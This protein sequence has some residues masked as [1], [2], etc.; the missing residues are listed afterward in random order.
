MQ[1]RYSTGT[2]EPTDFPWEAA[3]PVSTF[4]D[5]FTFKDAAC[6][7]KAIPVEELEQHDL[8]T[9]YGS[10][11][12]PEKIAVALD[13]LR[14]RLQREEAK[15][16]PPAEFCTADHNAWSHLWLAIAATSMDLGQVDVAEE[17]HRTLVVKRLDPN[18]LVPANNLCAFLARNTTKYDEAITLAGPCKE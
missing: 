15:Y 3:I 10:A 16:P 2:N 14:E 12:Q 5:S 1:F 11:T 7:I 17:A 13:I 6:I 9:R 18:D 4:W 8:D